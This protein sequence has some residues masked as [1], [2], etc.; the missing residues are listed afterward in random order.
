VKPTARKTKQPRSHLRLLLKVLLL[1][2]V[3]AGFVYLM[4][5]PYFFVTQVEIEGQETLSERSLEQDIQQYLHSSWMGLIPRKNSLFLGAQKLAEQLKQQQPRIYSVDLQVNNNVLS[6]QIQERSKHSLWCV[7]VQ[8]EEVFDEECYFADKRGFWYTKAP[9]LSDNV[10][11]KIYLPPSIQEISIGEQYMNTDEILE[12]FEFL[13]TLEN[14]YNTR[15]QKVVVGQYGDV[16]IYLNTKD[17][18]VFED[19]PRILF[20]SEDSYETIL[21]NIGIVVEQPDF[22]SDFEA[23]PQGFKTI[24]VRFDGRVFY[25]IN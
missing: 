20:N 21:R 14:Q 19:K 6:V 7:G 12:F 4:N 22:Q 1:V 2:I 18:V 16:E 8:Y 23:N 25:L 15:I 10:F 5:Q 17:G 24:D 13:D 3:F 11:M 9:Y